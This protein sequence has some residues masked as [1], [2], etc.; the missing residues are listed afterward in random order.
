MIKTLL[1]LSSLLVHLPLSA[2][3]LGTGDILKLKPGESLL[4]AKKKVEGLKTSDNLKGA[5]YEIETEKNLIT[6]VR[7][8]FKLP[9]NSEEFV[10]KDTKGFCLS[11]PMAPD[12]PIN[13]TF[14][15]DMKTQRRYELSPKGQIKSI[16]I[17]DIPGARTNRECQFGEALLKNPESEV[18]KSV[19]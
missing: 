17:Q 19:K 3:V 4:E 2:K 15:F 7:I 18:I 5:S 6:S 11:Q 9:V 16:V 13:R 1:I 14:F 8:D 12:I 10:S